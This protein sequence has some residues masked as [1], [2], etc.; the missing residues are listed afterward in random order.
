MCFSEPQGAWLVVVQPLKLPAHLNVAAG[1]QFFTDDTAN[2]TTQNVDTRAV[3]GHWAA[4]AS[5]SSLSDRS[6][7]VVEPLST[8]LAGEGMGIIQIHTSNT[9]LGAAS[10]HSPGGGVQE[11]RTQQRLNEL[12]HQLQ[13]EVK[14]D[15]HSMAA[16]WTLWG[17]IGLIT[18]YALLLF[19]NTL[20]TEANP[21]VSL[22]F[23]YL[24]VLGQLSTVP[25]TLE[26]WRV[27][28]MVQMGN[29]SHVCSTFPQDCGFRHQ[30]AAVGTIV[31][32]VARDFALAAAQANEDA[33]RLHESTQSPGTL[34]IESWRG[35]LAA[36]GRLTALAFRLGG[37]DT[38]QSDTWTEV[39]TEAAINLSEGAQTTAGIA[40]D[41]LHER[42]TSSLQS[43]FL[44]SV[45]AILISMAVTFTLSYKAEQKLLSDADAVLQRIQVHTWSAAPNQGKA[46][47]HSTHHL[48]NSTS[49]W[50][51]SARIWAEIGIRHKLIL[52]YFA[53]AIVVLVM[54]FS[55]FV[56]R[57]G[58]ED[59]QASSINAVHAALQL[60]QAGAKASGSLLRL[61]SPAAN[62]TRNHDLNG[63]LDHFAAW[64]RVLFSQEASPF[65]QSAAPGRQRQAA[66]SAS[67]GGRA[68]LFQDACSPQVPAGFTEEFIPFRLV[69]NTVIGSLHSSTCATFLNGLLLQGWQ[70]I[71][72]N[73]AAR[74]KDAQSSLNMW[75][76]MQPEARCVQQTHAAALAL[77][78]NSVAPAN[79][80]A[81]GSAAAEA[82]REAITADLS[83]ACLTNSPPAPGAAVAALAMR[84]A[85]NTAL[86]L[87]LQAVHF[88]TMARRAVLFGAASY[89]ESLTAY[90][91]NT[92]LPVSCV[93]LLTLIFLY[94]VGQP[95][96]LDR[97][98]LVQAAELMY[99]LL[100]AENIVG[101]DVHCIQED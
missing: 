4:H 96:A 47:A 7:S 101:M 58:P 63:A 24:A 12:R 1:F 11:L 81:R 8:Q 77:F 89:E 98:K 67:S 80:S 88:H 32:E 33:A 74:V 50:S 37:S 69:G 22:R 76:A 20:S 92:L 38:P 26:A 19:R 3:L 28:S 60:Q 68:L 30:R 95:A 61:I 51:S 5:V 31:N 13:R 39:D 23:R 56:T 9:H 27:A 75:L 2:N 94:A 6:P 91:W 48:R 64:Q 29:W 65:F 53:V 54:M 35:C 99:S 52:R 84:I 40:V 90:T 79:G 100:R 70:G 73:F 21:L 86:L 87:E 16:V 14:H 44:L 10:L 46:A 43:R 18:F 45:V 34:V 36:I 97:R 55:G 57:D 62:Q 82:M 72:F 78:L 15:K 71:S 59:T 49:R 41:M 17:N 93:P 42:Y 66:F 85:S 83:S 25:H